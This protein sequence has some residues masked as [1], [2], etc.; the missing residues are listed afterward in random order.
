[1]QAVFLVGGLGSRLGGLTRQTPKP[2]L[3]VGGRVFLDYLIEDVARHGFTD[4]LFLAQFEADQVRAFC[5]QSSAIARFGIRATVLEEPLKAGTGGALWHARDFLSDRFLLLNG[6][7]WLQGNYGALRHL[8][9]HT[10]VHCGVA[11]REVEDTGR[12]GR[13]ELDGQRITAFAE[14]GGV[15]ERGR[16]N[17]GVYFMQ[18]TVVGQGGPVCSLEAD[19]LPGVAREGALAGIDFPGYFI[20]IGLPE[21]FALAQ[22]EF[23]DAWQ[24]PALFLDR[25]GVLNVDHGHVGSIERFEW[26]DG[27]IDT[28]RRA[29]DM[30]WLVFVV[31]NQAGVAKG[32]YDEDAVQELHRFMQTE[33][34]AHGAHIDEYRY[35]PYHPE[36]VIEHYRRQSDDR[37]P[38][39][40][41][42]LDLMERW[43]VDKGA[44]L[45]VGDKESDVAAANAVGVASHLFTHQSALSDFAIDKF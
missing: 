42:L 18:K 35:C 17:G 2:L 43:P 8:V 4:M 23:V 37:K 22:T 39:P 27:A 45:M 10:N 14:R 28:V 32:Y 24:R 6:D 36:G 34:L 16:I 41:M 21:S 5:A 40:G 1:M 38:R 26:I 7:S 29:N 33:L 9:E 19:I 11:L 31:T 20:D 13:V 25:D 30:G 44:S 3:E 15:G 12:F